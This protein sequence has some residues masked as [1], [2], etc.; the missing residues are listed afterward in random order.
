MS[1]GWVAMPIAFLSLPG[2]FV[3]AMLLTQVYPLDES[4]FGLIVSLP[5]WCN[6]IQLIVVPFLAKQWQQKTVTVI[7][8]VLH[9]GAWAVLAVMLPYLPRDGS[10][11]VWVFLVLLF[12]A[13]SLFQ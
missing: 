10:N 9:L 3:I 7:F 1:D 6:V 4:R 8:G 2:N 12:S 13:S 5:A 11:W